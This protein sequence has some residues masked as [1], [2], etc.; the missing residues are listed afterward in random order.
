MQQNNDIYFQILRSIKF[1]RYDLQQLKEFSTVSQVYKEIFH[2]H[3]GF[4]EEGI[5]PLCECFLLYVQSLLLE[6]SDS[7]T[8]EVLRRK[9]V[10]REK[11]VIISVT[12]YIL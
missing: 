11:K 5:H 7:T 12:K 9:V 10:R 8:L 6:S 2:L 4:L 1:T 3:P